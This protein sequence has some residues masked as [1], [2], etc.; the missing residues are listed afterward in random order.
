MPATTTP[1][2]SRRR[3]AF[4]RLEHTLHPDAA[5]SSALFLA[6]SAPSMRKR[7]LG[8]GTTLLAA[9]TRT[10]TL[11]G[12]E[13]TRLA[14]AP[15]ANLSRD[16]VEVLA[17]DYARDVIL[18][19]LRPETE[20]LLVGARDDGFVP[21]LVAETVRAVAAPVAVA[22]GFDHVIANDLEFDDRDRAT[23]ALVEPFLGPEL[24]PRRLRTFASEHGFDLAASR[25]YGTV[26][27]DLV[28]LGAVGHPCAVEPDRELARV[29]RDL[30]WP[31]V[32][33]HRPVVHEPTSIETRELE[34]A[35]E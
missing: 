7:I 23:G 27:S 26:R 12:T 18:A 15:L 3:A 9:V 32:R 28:L 16:R 5:W 10:S 11:A 22:L 1:S 21:V 17:A 6:G 24:D 30:D 20:R 4:F 19:N 35:P 14:F 25:G 34:G 8:L 29:A 33:T 13:S 31:V 2:V